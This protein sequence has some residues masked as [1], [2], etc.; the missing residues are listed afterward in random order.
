[1]INVACLKFGNKY[2]PIYVN[3]LFYAVKRNLTLPFNFFCFTEK[4][5]G[6]HKDVNII[7]LPMKNIDGWWHKL[8]M[9]SENNPIDGRIF[10]LDLDTLVTGNLNEIASCAK[11]F[12]VLHDFFRIRMP[13]NKDK[14]GFGRDAV[15]SGVLSWE[16]GKHTHIWETFAKNPKKAVQSLHPHGDQ[17]WIER[18][19]KER[20]YWQDLFPNQ[21]VSFKV[22]CRSGLPKNARIVCYHGKPGIEESINSTTKVQGYNIKPTNWVKKYW[23]DEDEPGTETET[24]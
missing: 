18:H 16:S 20:L 17:K 15:G 4:P 5:G 19:Q 3:R 21:V 13:N 23:K 14:F 7:P 6:I 2:G 11:G 1:M 24:S 10:Y 8:Y 22:H 12:I 9:F